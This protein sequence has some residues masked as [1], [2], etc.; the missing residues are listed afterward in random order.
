MTQE[1]PAISVPLR[2]LI[3]GPAAWIGADMREREAEWSYRLSTAEIAEIDAAVKRVRARGLEIAEIQR[4]DFPL[5]TLGSVLDRLRVEVLDGRGFVLVRGLPVD[6]RPIAETVTA[7]WGIEPISAAPARRM[8]RDICSAMST[9]SAKGSA[10][11]IPICAAM[12]RRNAR[13]STSIAATSSHYCACGARSRADF[14]R[15]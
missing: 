14:R 2:P 12:R 8:H 11:P 1:A 10:R 3:E 15:S 4:E 6:D 5:P 9:T 7:Y 13:I